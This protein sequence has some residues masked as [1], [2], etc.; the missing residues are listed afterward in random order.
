KAQ[1]VEMKLSG[2]Q[3]EALY[4]E[5]LLGQCHAVHRAMPFLFEAVDDEAELLLPDN[6]TRTDSILR[7]L[8][9][10]IPEEDWEQ[11][12]VIGWLYQFY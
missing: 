10:D 3:N 5:L 1:L 11:V 2:N 4:R 6:L 7:G 9:D 12:E 8:V